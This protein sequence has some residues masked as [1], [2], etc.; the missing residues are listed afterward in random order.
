M[1]GSYINKKYCKKKIKL[2]SCIFNPIKDILID[3][4]TFLQ[5]RLTI[6]NR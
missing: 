4:R 2:Q 6:F 1:S 5:K 3:Y